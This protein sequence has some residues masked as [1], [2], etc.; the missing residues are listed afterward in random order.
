MID[1]VYIILVS[2][3]DELFDF[4]KESWLH[5]VDD[6]L[7][8]FFLELIYNLLDIIVSLSLLY[9]FM[10]LYLLNRLLISFNTL[11]VIRGL[12]SV[13]ILN[14]VLEIGFH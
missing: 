14:Q 6:F 10:Q 8:I 2:V 11:Q 13:F 4:L 9:P 12:F 5:R 1:M 7:S 3:H